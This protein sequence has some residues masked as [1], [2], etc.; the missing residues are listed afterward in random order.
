MSQPKT[1]APAGKKHF[2]SEIEEQILGTWAK[3]N[4]FEKS[5]SNRQSSPH[6]SFYDGPPFANGQPHFGHS[7]VTSIKDSILRYKTMRGMLVPRRNGW[8]C[9][10]LPV[11][12]TIEK[13]LGV[14]GKKQILELGLK[15]FNDACRDSIFRYKADWEAF[16]SRIGRWSDYEHSY[17][18]VDTNYTESVW[19]ILSEINKKGLLY[20]GF[21]SL[22]YCPRCA[23]PL[24]NFELNEG[25]KDNV[26]DPSVFAL[27]PLVDD[28]KTSFLVWTTTPW[29]LPANAALAIDS[30]ADYAVVE[31][32][33]DG[34]GLILAKKRLNVL[35]L[36]KSEYKLLKTLKGKELV[37]LHYEPLYKLDEKK[38]TPEQVANA[39]QVFADE[40][41]SLEDGTGI[42][43]VAPRYGETDLNL[44]QKE[45]LPLIES[46]DSSGH[47]IHGPD[48]AIG[49]FFKTADKHII[50]DLSQK[51][52]IFAA[53]TAEHTYP[54][55][56]RCE[57][58]LMYFATTTWFIEV[59]KVKDQ[60]L[61]TA[62]DINWVPAHIKTGRFGKWLEGS[63]DWAISRNRYWGAPMPIW[64]NVDDPD[65]YIVI[66]SIAELEELAG[67]AAVQKALPKVETDGSLDLHRP[68]IDEIVIKKDSKTYKRVEE[69]LDCW[70]ESGSMPVAQWHYPFENK[71]LF[72][73]TFPADFITEGLDQTRL[74]FYVQ[75]V[76]ATIL[77]NRPAF[78]NVI[79]NGMILAA[80]GQKLSKRLRNYPPIE[81]VFGH[82]GVDDLRLYFLSSTQATETA[83]YIRFNR[84]GLTDIQRN[85][86]DTL[87]NSFKFF[88]TY[89]KLDKWSLGFA[90]STDSTS[91]PLASSEQD[92]DKQAG[93]QPPQSDSILDQWIL[94]RL[95][96]TIKQ[97]TKSADNYKIAHA[98]GPVFELI[99]DL[100]N[101]YIRRS[102]RRFWRPVHRSLGGG[103]K[104][105][106]DKDKNQAY[107]TLHY[108]LARICQLLAPWAP[109]ISDD[110][111]RQLIK[112][113]KEQ[114]SVHLTDWPKPDKASIKVLEEMRMV[115]EL[116]ADGLAQRAA[117]KI[118]VR[119]PLSAAKIYSPWGW[120]DEAKRYAD[121]VAEE[122]NVKDVKWLHS[123]S[124]T[125]HS[126]EIATDITLELKQEG[127]MRE[128]VRVIQNARKN[129]GLKV[130]DRIKLRIDSEAAEITEAV[131]KFKDIIFAETLATG[132]LSGAGDHVETVKIEAQEA[133]ISLSKA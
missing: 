5:L 88:Q 122:L 29:T 35:D 75:H 38:F 133:K 131:T 100:S 68:F 28:P 20:R 18:T 121:I 129:A 91:S 45:N 11:E 23:T 40:S 63:R 7:L 66:G 94:A 32:K 90:P 115:R 14:S 17:A 130:D 73:K 108:V 4:T 87:N 62:E 125:I 71:D 36:R 30:K 95:S 61:K 113:T 22:P 44:G 52:K 2:G 26:P 47:L 39:G 25:Y 116:I 69:V 102:R 24:S 127:I 74:W 80:D 78:K 107:A 10:G 33:A 85:V 16:M 104:S 53:E 56:W 79:V 64:Q 76:I 101:W 112:G 98:I 37:G 41:V 82:E 93:L 97:A 43:H 96:Q 83:D 65:D 114:G 86:L 89:S 54:F 120:G 117:A 49:K 92:R 50:A 31:L 84:E 58:P 126:I 34:R 111:W 3:E 110:L 42:L 124:P 8:D 123:Q 118:K 57:T 1:P 77:F 81:E 51:G 27:F 46:V 60:M 128:L 15:K 119:Q 19:W 70:F 106:N 103:G 67:K 59:T 109:F 55:C 13:D 21:K 48:N 99:D 12:F 132:E 9:H 105:E 6:F 72:E